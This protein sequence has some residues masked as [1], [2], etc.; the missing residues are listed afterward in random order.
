[1]T[2]QQLFTRN[3]QYEDDAVI[4]LDAVLHKAT[5]ETCEFMEAI[6]KDDLEEM[7]AEMADALTN[8]L[9]VE[10]RLT[11]SVDEFTKML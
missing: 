9:S 1:M 8:I 2:L 10:Y 11:G 6:Q 4:D 3:K 7:V 5:Q